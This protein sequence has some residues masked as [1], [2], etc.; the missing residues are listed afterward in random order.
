LS[1]EEDTELAVGDA[2]SDDGADAALWVDDN[3]GGDGAY[4]KGIHGAMS[5]VM[6]AVL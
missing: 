1:V 6:E 5:E 4:A 3:I 2:A